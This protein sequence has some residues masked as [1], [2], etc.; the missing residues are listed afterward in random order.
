MPCAN[1]KCPFNE[2]RAENGPFSADGVLCMLSTAVQDTR[3][4][5]GENLFLQ[6]QTSSSLYSL[7]SGMVKI[8]S[9]DTDGR[10]QIVGLASPGK[11]LVGLQSLNDPRYIYSATAATEVHACRINHRAL[12]E[13]MRDRTDI[14]IRLIDAVNTQLAHSRALMQAMGHKCAAAKIASFL[15]LM[16][17][18]SKQGNGRFQLPFSR[19]EIAGLLG[20]S[21]ETVCRMMANM[22]RSG[23]I[24]A[25]RGSIEVK[26]RGRL[27]AIAD[28]AAREHPAA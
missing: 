23:V 8:W 22:K 18:G 24:H 11:L 7:T 15:L 26:D 20:L 3:F 19:L 17:P 14:A 1:C 6:G 2:L 25:P 27:R 16:A 21:E 12:L 4:A 5:R 10:E 28:G 9:H 13:S